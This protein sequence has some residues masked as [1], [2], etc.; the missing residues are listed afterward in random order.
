M[1]RPVTLAEGSALL[2][3]NRLH[4]L[5]VISDALRGLARVAKE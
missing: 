2:L 1:Q 3:K 4:I 5:A